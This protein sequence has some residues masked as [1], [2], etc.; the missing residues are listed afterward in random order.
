[1]LKVIS[2]DSDTEDT[3]VST[4]GTCSRMITVKLNG[5]NV[6]CKYIG[7]CK[8]DIPHG[9]GIAIREDNGHAISTLWKN[10]NIEFENYGIV[11]KDKCTVLSKLN[12]KETIIKYQN[13]DVF[14][15]VVQTDD[16]D[17]LT[18]EGTKIY[19]NGTIY[20]GKFNKGNRN[21]N[22]TIQFVNNAKLCCT[23]HEN[24]FQENSKIEV[25]YSD[26][27]TLT[28]TVKYNGYFKFFKLNNININYS[29]SLFRGSIYDTYSDLDLHSFQKIPKKKEGE[30]LE[31]GCVVKSG[32][33]NEEGY[34]VEGW[35]INFYD[36]KYEGKWDEYGNLIEGKI[37]DNNGTTTEGTFKWNEQIFIKFN[38]KITQRNEPII[39][40][41]GEFDND[42]KLVKGK[43]LYRNGMIVEGDFT[44]DLLYKGKITKNN[45][46]YEG[47][48]FVDEKI[49]KGKI[50]YVNISTV[51]EG[52]FDGNDMLIEG[53][54][55]DNDVIS[56]GTFYPNTT[57]LKKGK[58]TF[59]KTGNVYEGE[60]STDDKFVKGILRKDNM[61]KDGIWKNGK[62]TGKG[63]IKYKHGNIY[64]GDIVDDIPNGKGTKLFAQSNNRKYVGGWKDGYMY[65]E[66]T[67][68][69]DDKIVYKG[70]WGSHG[71]LIKKV[72]SEEVNVPPNSKKRPLKEDKV[73]DANSKKSKTSDDK[74]DGN[75]I[76]FDFKCPICLDIF[77]DPVVCSNGITY[78]EVCISKW[79]RKDGR[80]KDP[81]G[82]SEPLSKHRFPNV[83]LNS[84]I[85]EYLD[86]K[87]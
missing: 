4:E 14:K 75:D 43:K 34:F 83:S 50:T 32:K 45:I 41:E 6:R 26:K 10:G 12:G 19:S 5:E 21:G 36:I 68:Y 13:G 61:Y 70:I 85:K 79:C 33:W 27:Q 28:G 58:K 67:I 55:T 47:D 37:C 2:V 8:D 66:G 53:K 30:I 59:I 3:Y 78:C 25:V 57:C 60:F 9:L 64:E 52:M 35:K 74:T 16:F 73:T 69:A 15:G 18:G 82:G 87:Q 76:P 86:K 44:N 84:M 17:N 42:Y 24:K 63:N 31:N 1:M 56:E 11:K 51:H 40:I 71:K 39:T 81:H 7:M 80:Y 46:I 54:I 49:R 77:T 65:G 48:I 38:G 62:F 23:F 20:K 72:Y 29:N 22:C